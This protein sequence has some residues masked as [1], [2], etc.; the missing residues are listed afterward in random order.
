MGRNT[1]Q[2]STI[3]YPDKI[4]TVDQEHVKLL[5]DSLFP[6]LL[7]MIPSRTDVV[8]IG[9][10]CGFLS[11]ILPDYCSYTGYESDPIKVMIAKSLNRNVINAYIPR[12]ALNKLHGTVIIMEPWKVWEPLAQLDALLNLSNAWHAKHYIF[13]YHLSVPNP[14][15]LTKLFNVVKTHKYSLFGNNFVLSEVLA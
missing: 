6:A 7:N 3:I 11:T 13:N 14:Y 4:E 15:G 1:G 8:E 10:G 5:T 9:C 2:K 12:Y